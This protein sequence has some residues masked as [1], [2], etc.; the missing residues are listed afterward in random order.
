MYLPTVEALKLVITPEASRLLT[1]IS[2]ILA[3]QGVQSYL[4]GGFV[5]DI[6]LG[7]ATADIDIAVAADAPEIASQ[8]ASVLGGRYV[9]LDKENGVGRVVRLDDKNKPNDSE[10]E[11]DFATLQ[12]DI[13]ADLARRDFTIDAM[14]IGLDNFT[15]SVPDTAKIIDPFHSRDDLEKGIIRAV[16]ETCFKDDAVRLIRGVRLAAELDFIIDSETD[17]LIRADSCTIT[18]VAGERTREELLRLLALPRAGRWLSYLDDTGLLTA[19]I[20]ELEASRGVDQPKMHVWDVLKHSLQTVRTVEFLLRESGLDYA[21]EELL[22]TVPWTE[23]IRRHFDAEISRGSTR[24]SLLKLAALLHDIAKPQTKSTDA[25]GRT[26][27]LRHSEEGAVVTAKVLERLR[28]STKEIKLVELLVKYHLR[29]TQM[30]REELPTRRAIYRYFRDTGVAGID[31][32]FLSLADHL[33]AR[34]AGLD[35]TQWGEHCRTVEYILTQHTEETSLPLPVKL[36]DGHD[37]MKIFGLSPGPGVG[38]LLEAVNEARAVG[39]VQTRQQAME[40]IK[41]L[42]N[43][44]TRQHLSRRTRGKS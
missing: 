30:G 27:F 18:S 11:I 17:I 3:E 34:G 36:I 39:E 22:A 41:G 13:T 35:I 31:I 38:Q 16:S 25:T 33:A 8:V 23:D 6:M 10:W 40:Y 24:R 37:I 43:K 9:L 26:R 4:V 5:R 19:L 7:R 29:P 32:L 12:G 21:G 14:A 2:R 28:F 44:D 42:I 1:E 15:A 20:P